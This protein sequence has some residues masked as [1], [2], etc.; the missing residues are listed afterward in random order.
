MG[1][2]LVGL[3]KSAG[4]FGIWAIIFTESGI[5]FGILLPGDTLLFSAGILA[6]QGYFEIFPLVLG[7]MAAAF[8]GNLVGYEIGKRYGLPFARKYARRFISSDQLDATNRFFT[9]HRLTTIVVARFVPLVRTIAPFLAGV[10]HMNYRL[11]VL[12]S[13]IGA[14]VWG[15]GLPVVGYYLG[16]Y[17]PEGWMELLILPVIFVILA[18]VCWPYVANYLKRKRIYRKRKERAR[19][20]RS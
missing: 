20:P 6:R 12:H 11:F 19:F 8:L 7:C 4:Y 17:I 16:K 14:I 13:A 9:R 2:E 18:C 15:A 3:I 5:L 10:I 1:F